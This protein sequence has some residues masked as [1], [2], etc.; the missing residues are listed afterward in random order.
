[1]S[2][3]GRAVVIGSG[4]GG[5]T[6]AR[7]LQLSGYDVVVLE[8]HTRPG[9]MLHRFF[10]EGVPYDTGFHYC[11]SVQAGQPLGQI[12]RH[13]GVF[14]DLETHALDPDGF[15]R[16]RFP[17]LEVPVPRGWD[18]YADVLCAT[19]P[20]EARG[21]RAVL[22]DLRAAVDAY[23]L[24]RMRPTEDLQAVIA[25][26][27]RSLADAIRAEVR[28]PRVLA[29]LGGQSVLYG[30]APED[31]SFGVHALVLDHFLQGATTVR[32]GGDRLALALTRR[33]RADA[34]E[35]RLRTEAV[36]VEVRDGRATAV[37][38]ADGDVLPADVVVSNLHPRLTLELLPEEATR[39]AY[40]SRVRDAAV[41]HAHLGVYLQVDGRVPELGDHNVYRHPSWDPDRSYR[42]IAPGS[43][44][45]Y[46]ASAPSEHVPD[47]S[48]P[49]VVLM[50]AP[51]AWES[52]ERWSGSLHGDR[53]EAYEDLKGR[54]LDTAVDALLADHPGLRGRI[55][56][57]EAST[58]LSTAHFTRSP[59][60][61]TY[62]HLHSRAQMGRHRPSQRTRVPN[63]VLVGQGVFSPG[64]LGTALSGYYGVGHL[65]GLEPLLEALR[66]A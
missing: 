37:R 1:M 55:V 3:A 58:P 60:G 22:G 47:P 61:A 44:G 33:I 5:L 46:F 16:L 25:L 2:G 39:R 29:V 35:V 8:Q 57:R 63:L 41:G 36:G 24:Y 59:R 62:G 27:E 50:I 7:L 66:T 26:E 6:A 28:D 38:T 30:V 9:G 54:L 51:L 31:A 20:R 17:D 45:L 10:R 18:A 49:G 53:P 4:M 43:C 11:G 65:V 48:G 15:D 56:R 32:G 40:R 42:S 52:V 13:L 14:D 64:V 23:G 34:G 12:L 19:F 21:I